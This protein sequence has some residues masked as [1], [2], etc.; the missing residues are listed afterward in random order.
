MFKFLLAKSLEKR[1][2][3]RQS[4]EEYAQAKGAAKLTGHVTAVLS[5]AEVLSD[6][7]GETIQQQLRLKDASRLKSIVKLG[8]YLHDWG[9]ANQHFQEM[10][11]LKSSILD[12][13]SKARLEKAW[14]AHNKQQL[15]RHEFLSG[16]LAL[17]VSPFREWL[18]K[19]FT[20]EEL[21]LATWAAIGHHLKAG[22][23]SQGKESHKITELP[24]GTGTEVRI[25]TDHRDFQS[26][27][28]LGSQRLGLPEEIPD[29]PSANWKK[30]QLEEHLHTLA[31]QFRDFAKSLSSD[32]RALVAAAKATVIVA[33]L[34]GSILPSEGENLQDWIS[35]TLS[36]ILQESELEQLVTQKLGGN[37][38]RPFQ[39]QIANTRC[40]VTLVK[41]GCG[42]GKTLGAYAW[43]K[44]WAVGKRL[45]FGYP[46]T[47][48][49][50]QGYLDYAEGSPIEKMLMHSR[51]DLDRELLLTGEGEKDEA[52]SSRLAALQAWRKKL[53][54]CTVDSIL[55]L[56]QNNRRSLFSWPVLAQSAFVFDEVHAYD[57]QLFGALLRFLRTFRGAPVL[58]M[59]AS[60]TPGQLQAIKRVMDELGE[61]I[62][63][64]VEGSREL[65]ELKRY[66]IQE[67][68]AEGDPT[69]SELIWSKV[70]KAVQERQK[71][72]WVTNSV[73]SCIDIYQVAKE[74]LKDIKVKVLIYHSRF[75]YKDR[76]TKHEQVI[77]AFSRPEPVLAVTT[78]V[79]EMSLDLSADLLVSAMAPATALVQ[80]LG[81]LNR[82]MKSEKEEPCTALLYRWDKSSPYTAEELESGQKLVNEV[83]YRGLERVSQRD[84]ASILSQLSPKEPV[85]VKSAWLD[86]DWCTYPSFLRESG[87]TITV[88]LAEDQESIWEAAKARQEKALAK[89]QKLSKM[90]A[91]L[92]EAQ[93]WAIPIRIPDQEIEWWNWQRRGFYFV[94][95]PGYI[96]Y[97]E[98]SGTP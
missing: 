3:S 25:Y 80:R 96:S 89:G 65:E 28:R 14:R 92:Q 53:I 26:I 93:A 12:A 95:E 77:N 49:A 10:I 67:V 82:R 31:N 69:H 36:L 33:D 8:S 1:D 51:A 57:N 47:G 61:P 46:T 94:T 62:E 35:N 70:I 74:K 5:A 78:Q 43:A 11:Y 18:R 20:E 30:E 55:G 6:H 56:M 37:S 91:F 40:R 23:D 72:L 22:V 60:F 98:E 16:I 86:Q 81:R 88:L 85:E 9:K 39:E 68:Q 27:L 97:S 58:L 90:Q 21:L 38:L 42:T 4:E 45:F 19:A 64:P 48:T 87:H 54:I 66:Q 50:T 79:C 59:S 73:S 83:K 32:Q 76:L 7:L 63:D 29:V 34:A 44:K 24:D 15:I 17:Q 2:P 52:T 71:V 41:A 13:E 84:L 75:R